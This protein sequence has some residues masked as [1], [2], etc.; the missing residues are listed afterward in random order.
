MDNNELIPHLFRQESAK[1]IAVLCQ[2]F[3]IGFIDAAEDITSETFQAALETWPYKGVP[4]NPAAWL[5]AVAK[6]KAINYHKRTQLFETKISKSYLAAAAYAENPGFLENPVLIQDSQLQMLFCICHPAIGTSSQISLAL[7]VLCGFGIEEIAHALLTNKE[8][9]SKRILRA[10][11]TLRKEQVRVEMPEENKLQPRIQS[12]VRTIYLLFNEGYYSETSEAIIREDL[13]TEAIRLGYMLTENSTTNLPE[14]N[15]L[16]ALMCFHSSRLPARKSAKGEIVLYDDQ[17][18]LQWN[19]ELIARGAAYFHTSSTGARITKYH[20]EAGIAFWHTRKED[21]QEKWEAIL[22]LYNRLLQVEYSPIAALNRTFALA[23]ATGYEHAI[24]EA[25]KLKLVTNP[26]YFSLLGELYRKIDPPKALHHL[27][28][29]ELLSKNSTEKELLRKKQ[30]Q[31][32]N[33][34]ILTL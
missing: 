23:K 31:L 1:I 14:T 28:Q 5:F 12:V 34:S 27:Q 7:R 25:E 4:E 26:Y 15:A 32:R 17:D 16:M 6:N 9:V 22:Q 2:Q 33:D 24:V 18:A 13:C 19:A 21:T 20:L 10:K 11:E 30:E 29:A 8:T 3:G